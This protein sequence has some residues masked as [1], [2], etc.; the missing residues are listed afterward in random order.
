[1]KAPGG[2]RGGGRFRGRADIAVVT[3]SGLSP[4]RWPGRTLARAWYPSIEGMSP[5]GVEGHPGRVLLLDTGAGNL[6][7]FAGR[8]HFYEGRGWKAAGSAASAAA[9][10]GCG[11]ILFVQAAGSLKRSL[12]PGSWMLP[13]QTVALP[14]RFTGSVPPA[15]PEISGSFRSRVAAAAAAAGIGL[16]GGVLYWAS[17]PAYETPAE[18]RAALLMGADAATMSPLPELVEAAGNGLEAACL[19]YITN[20]APSVREGPSGHG[21]VLEAA[22]RGA[23]DLRALL[24]ELAKP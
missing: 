3:G 16:E 18:A 5:P 10:M 24:V 6:L 17:G 8:T 23:A 14:A 9:A 7:G 11:R 1:M 15:R 12:P 19:T 4:R 2:E 20:Y 22:R 13:A 21:E